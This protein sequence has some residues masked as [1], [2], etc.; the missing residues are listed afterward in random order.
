[1]C[2]SK[3]IRANAALLCSFQR[4]GAGEGRIIDRRD[5]V[6]ADVRVRPVVANLREEQFAFTGQVTGK[7]F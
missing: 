2:S 1:M 5:P 4:H 3:S 7:D 6:Y